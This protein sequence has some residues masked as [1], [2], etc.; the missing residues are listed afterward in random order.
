VARSSAGRVSVRAVA[1]LR[2]GEPS[3]ASFKRIAPPQTS[4]T[5]LPHCTRHRGGLSCNG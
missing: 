3:F 5:S 4:L 1:K 2:Q